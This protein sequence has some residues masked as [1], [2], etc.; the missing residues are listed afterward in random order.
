VTSNASSSLSP[1]PRGRTHSL[2]QPSTLSSGSDAPPV[3]EA[4]A[5]SNEGIPKSVAR[6]L[7]AARVRAEWRKR[8]AGDADA[9]DAA[10]SAPPKKKRKHGDDGA[11]RKGAE[12][13]S[14]RPGESLSHFNRCVRA[15]PR[16]APR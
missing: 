10:G 8:R 9:P 1:A 7:D 13:M 6:V 16:P 5:L 3:A 15:A 12:G 14:I 11:A 2:I 4:R